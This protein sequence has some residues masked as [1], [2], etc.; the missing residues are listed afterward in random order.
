MLWIIPCLIFWGLSRVF[1]SKKASFRRSLVFALVMMPL[2]FLSNYLFWITIGSIL[3]FHPNIPLQLIPWI[4]TITPQIIAFVIA[5]L[6]SKIF[7]QMA[8]K[9]TLLFAF[10]IILTE[11]LFLQTMLL[12]WS[13]SAFFLWFTIVMNPNL[14]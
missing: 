9:K 5:A 7:Y 8:W 11:F 13:F 4:N 2:Y 14:P 6:I 3:L 1:R 12:L 10:F